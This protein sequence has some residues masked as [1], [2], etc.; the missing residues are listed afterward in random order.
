KI[1]RGLAG[2]ELGE[3][4]IAAVIN[5]TCRV[6]AAAEPGDIDG[7]LVVGIGFSIPIENLELDLLTRLGIRRALLDGEAAHA[8]DSARRFEVLAPAGGSAQ[9]CESA[10]RPKASNAETGTHQNSPRTRRLG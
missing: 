2:E 5:V 1:A 7:A 9:R 3:L 6:L 8:L 10:G 4:R